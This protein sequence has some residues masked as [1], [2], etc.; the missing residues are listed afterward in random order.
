MADWGSSFNLHLIQD[1]YFKYKIAFTGMLMCNV[2][3]SPSKYSPWFCWWTSL[4]FIFCLRKLSGIPTLGKRDLWKNR[5]HLLKLPLHHLFICTYF[6]S[7][8][9]FWHSYSYK[10]VMMNIKFSSVIFLH[11]RICFLHIAIIFIILILS[12]HDIPSSRFI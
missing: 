2:S 1:L 3:F 11:S 12:L 7:V 10:I 6:F 4:S 8:F 9:S 5:L